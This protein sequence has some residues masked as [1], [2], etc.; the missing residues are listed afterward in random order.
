MITKESTT[1]GGAK[2]NDHEQNWADAT[3][4]WDTRS[5]KTDHVEENMHFVCVTEGRSE[6]II[7]ASGKV[8]V[9]TKV[10]VRS[11]KVTTSK[12]MLMFLQNSNT[13]DCGTDA[14]TKAIILTGAFCACAARVYALTLPPIFLHCSL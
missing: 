9:E 14:T 4:Q 6:Q 13:C 8:R 12:C 5:N 2:V 11:A 7:H 3:K 10:V 1:N